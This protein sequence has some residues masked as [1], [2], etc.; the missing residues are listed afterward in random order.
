MAW[1]T[2][3][4]LEAL[5][6]S[7]SFGRGRAY[8]DAVTNVRDLPNGV[9]ATVH[10]SDAYQVRLYDTDGEL[11]GECD[12]PYG[13]QGNFCKHCVAVGLRLLHCSSVTG[14]ARIRGTSSDAGA[15]DVRAFLGTLDHSELVELVWAQ[16]SQ[17]PVLYQRML[18][19]AIAA[20]VAAAAR[21]GPGSA[22]H[23]GDRR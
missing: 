21:G 11:D 3:V 15:V 4:D 16:T 17:D 22:A 19:R 13:E 23:P 1:F 14:A 12:C 8:I 2:E 9:V 6:D 5:A 20:A 10:G 18:L 7:R